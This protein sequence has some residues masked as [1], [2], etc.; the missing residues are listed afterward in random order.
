MTFPSRPSPIALAL[1]F[2]LTGD[3]ALNAQQLPSTSAKTL[4]G[5]AATLPVPEHLQTFLVVG[6]SKASSDAV[7]A[8]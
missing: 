7:K 5:R 3:V 4:S 8:R 2:A 1:L 6:F